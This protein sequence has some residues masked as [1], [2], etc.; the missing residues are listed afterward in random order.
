VLTKMMAPVLSFTAEEIWSF[1]PKNKE[2]S[3]FLTSFP[4]VQP[5]FMDKE[6]EKKWESLSSICDEVNKALEIKRQQKFIG[7]S[8]EAKVILYVDEAKYKILEGYRTFLPTLF[9]VS[10]AEVVKDQSPP[11]NSYKSPL[12]SGMAVLIEKAQ[13][14]KCS[15]CWNWSVTVG[16]YKDFPE[17]C[18]RCHEVLT[19]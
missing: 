4:E 2:E 13:G 16:K 8:L 19:S 18:A 11:D 3:I 15:R 10:A 6:L 7:N 17:L 5:E 1:I 12:I 14:N 9:I